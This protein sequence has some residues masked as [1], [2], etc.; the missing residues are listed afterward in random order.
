M[1]RL[2]EPPLDPS[3]GEGRRWLA[4]ELARPEYSTQENPVRRAIRAVIEWFLGLF[5]SEAGETISWWW[6]ALVIIAF[7]VILALIAWAVFRI[8]PGRR[9]RV[10]EQ[11]G[12]FD[13]AGISAAEYLARARAAAAEGD[14]SRAVLD[15]YRSISADAIERFIL[16]DLPGATAREIA[17]SLA[18]VFPDE[19]DTLR[20]AATAFGAVRY[21]DVRADR[22]SAERLLALQGRIAT[23][24]PLLEEAP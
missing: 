10:T 12:V 22:A 13:E 18:P 17:H 3:S 6:Y 15:A 8:Q 1:H 2:A 5:D 9:S 24:Q 21:G 4:D 23:A 11:D 7:A 16:D 20:E 19:R 14:F